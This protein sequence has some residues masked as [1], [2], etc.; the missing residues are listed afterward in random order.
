M[1]PLGERGPRYPLEDKCR[2]QAWC[3]GIER[4]VLIRT[5]LN[6]APGRKK[7]PA[8]GVHGCMGKQAL[9]C[10]PIGRVVCMAFNDRMGDYGAT[11]ILGHQLLM[12]WVLRI[13]SAICRARDLAMV[14]EGH[15]IRAAERH[16]PILAGRRITGTGPASPLHFQ[17]II[18][19]GPR[20]GLS[21]AVNQ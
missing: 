4:T 15:F 5:C 21:G 14:R 13:I 10:M 11:I 12:I 17:P 16:L 19:I 9:P 3:T 1:P 2:E 20:R 7:M 8:P 18:D 6:K